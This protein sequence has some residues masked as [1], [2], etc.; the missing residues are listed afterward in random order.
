MNFAAIMGSLEE[1]TMTW[2]EISLEARRRRD[3]LI[4]T[5]HRLSTQFLS[6]TKLI[7]DVSNVHE[8][9][10]LF[11]ALQLEIIS[12]SAEA[13][14]AKAAKSEWKAIDVTN[15]FCLSASVA[16]QLVCS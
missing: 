1:P 15:A 16:Q 3:A 9:T 6:A 11:T 8:A 5:E 7:T 10:G 2:Q 14:L 4:P 12:S 13:I